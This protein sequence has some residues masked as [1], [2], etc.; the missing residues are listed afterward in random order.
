M[1]HCPLL[2]WHVPHLGYTTA[3]KE[4]LHQ[5]LQVKGTRRSQMSATLLPLDCKVAFWSSW[6][7]LV[8]LSFVVASASN[9]GLCGSLVMIIG[10][11]SYSYHVS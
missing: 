6:L 7:H 10:L 8:P 2:L 4:V 1:G 3:G 11:Q 9:E 5:P